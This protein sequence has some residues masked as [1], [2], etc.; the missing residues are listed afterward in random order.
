MNKLAAFVRLD[1]V[2]IKPYFTVKNLM[3]Y[4]VLAVF[5]TIIS[6]SPTSGMGVLIGLGSMFVSYPFALG[7]KSG[8]DTLYTTLSLSRKTVVSGR[9]LFALI[10]N[11]YVV[12]LSYLLAA[13]GTVAI[14]ASDF[15]E[16]AVEMLFTSLVLAAIFIVVQSMQ[17]PVYFK[18]GYSKAKF[19]S[20]IPFVLMMVFFSLFA[21]MSESEFSKRISGQVLGFFD[22]LNSGLFIVCVVSALALVVFVSYRLSLSFYRK[23]E[24]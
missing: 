22:T 17:L 8:I 9:Y 20:M 13:V 23:R 15:K 16:V 19:F 10:L 14:R 7:E 5:F 4:G 1:F 2:T 3:I 18:L 6:S 12:L 24:F 21:T 11:L